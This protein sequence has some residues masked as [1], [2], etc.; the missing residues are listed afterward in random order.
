MTFIMKHIF[1]RFGTPLLIISDSSMRFCEEQIDELL[2][3]YG[4]RYHV[5]LSH[6]NLTDGS[7]VEVNNELKQLLEMIVKKTKEDWSLKIYN[8]L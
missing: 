8:T 7:S 6:Y 1:R 5:Y 4:S 2:V 3:R